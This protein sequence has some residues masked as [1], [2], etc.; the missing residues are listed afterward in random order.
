MSTIKKVLLEQGECKNLI[1]YMNKKSLSKALVN[2]VIDSAKTGIMS[3]LSENTKTTVIITYDEKRARELYEDFKYYSDDIYFYPGK[4][5]IFINADIHGN[6]IVFERLKVIKNIIEDKKQII[7]TTMQAL[8]DKL[9][10]IS[11][12]KENLVKI[13]I[14]DEF[15]INE[16]VKKLTNMNYVRR[17]MVENKGEFSIRGEIIDIFPTSEDNPVRIDLWGD[18]IDSIKYFDK[19]SQRSIE[20]IDEIEIYPATEYIMDDDR[21]NEGIEKIKA[22]YEKTEKRFRKNMETEKAHRIKSIINEFT[23]QVLLGNKY[24]AFDSYINYFYDETSSL[25]DYIEDGV[26]IIDE[27]N[28]VKG[29][30]KAVMDE[31]Y[32]SM[33]GRLD[34]GYILPGQVELINNYKDILEK[35][36]DKNVL[37]FSAIDEKTDFLEEKKF[38]IDTRKAIAY[39]NNIEIF[40]NDIL[41]YKKKKYKVL[42]LGGSESRA[43]RLNDLLHDYDIESVYSE[44]FCRN[45]QKGEVVVTP[46]SIS[47]GYEFPLINFVCI[48]KNDILTKSKKKRKRVHK[49]VEGRKISSFSELN[50]GDYVVHE[51][52]G[53]GIYRGIE[54][55]EM[56]GV[57]KDYMK[58]EYAGNSNLYILASGLDLIQ[59]YASKD[60]KK[61]PKINKLGGTEWKNTKTRVKGAVGEIA[62]NLVELYSIRENKKGFAF[63]KDDVW[64]KEFEET[65]P[66]EET[67][68]QLKAIEDTKH[69]MESTR[70]MDR[71]IC[72]DVGFGKTE[73]A[74][75]AAFKAVSNGKQVAFLVPTTILARQHFNTFTQRMK[76]FPVRVDMLSRFQNATEVNNTIKGIKS[77]EVDIVIG[78]HK[79]FNKNIKYKDLGLLI[80]D[81]EQRFGVGH[82]EKIKE[83]KKDVDVITL[84]ATPIPRTLHMS[85]VGIRDMSLLEEAPVNRQP[86]QTYVMEYDEEMVREAINRELSRDGQ[87]Y[88]VYNNIN[89]IAEVTNNIRKLCPNAEIVFAHGRM[90][91]RELEDIMYD[92]VEGNIDV[93]I[94][95]TIIETGLD[96]P[97]VNTIIIHDADKFGLSQLYQLRGRVGRSGRNA[98]AFMLYRRDKMLK[99]E[100]T[101][102]LAAIKEF[103][104]LGSGFKISMSDLEIRGAG[105]VLGAEQHGHMAEVGYDLYVKLLNEAVLKLKGVEV[106][107]DFETKIDLDVDAFIPKEYISD[108]E[109][110]L[111]IYKKIASIESEEEFMDVED[112]LIDRFGEPPKKV[113]NLLNIALI[114]SMAH[115][116]WITEISS[117]QYNREYGINGEIRFYLFEN[118]KINPEK[119]PAL[120]DSYKGKLKFVKEKSPYLLYKTDKKIVDM[121]EYKKII[122]PIIESVLEMKEKNEENENN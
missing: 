22:Q 75:R 39:N 80:I 72:G 76:D 112:E 13:N 117:K 114:K 88:Y 79:I 11:F 119:L 36:K 77:G 121:E 20:S 108:E 37:V 89:N 100:A 27:S 106:L 49:K 81:E 102:R 46:G 104:D 18:E 120:I 99:E 19:D 8:M 103:T 70:I 48:S 45:L 73:I 40:T 44:D 33:E 17:E 54:K 58:I 94:S 97:N 101:K 93:L 26:F 21:I 12:I 109:Q 66:Y 38:Y 105:N 82:K 110:K 98:Y 74:L 23:E 24:M 10:P 61:P 78:T 41:S 6:E 85:L 64:Q 87:V 1:D 67:Y 69:D 90:S 14:N 111:N 30:A 34:K 118:A 16:V 3:I 63:G 43:K 83:L 84:S 91:K 92:F 32:D 71:L 9:I 2:G 42:I 51:N 50:V 5:L 60:S 95:T 56:D 47:K 7:I 122:I 53:M 68:D 55:I 57:S 31:F 115:S 15:K 59:K 28:L 4:E 25:I 113:I 35:L 96:I 65:F 116:A 29:S 52:H 62:K 107:S 86:I